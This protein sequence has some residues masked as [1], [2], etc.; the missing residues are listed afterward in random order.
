MAIVITSIPAPCQVALFDAI[1]REEPDFRAVYLARHDGSAGWRDTPFQHEGIFLEEPGDA[2]RVLLRS[3]DSADLVVFADYG[4]G[5]VRDAMRRREAV[6]RPWCFWGERPGGG[7][8]GRMWRN[9]YLAPLHRNRHAA[10]WGIGRGAVEEYRREFGD[11]RL[12]CNFPYVSDLARF[13]ESGARRAE[14]GALRILYAGALTKRNGADLVAAAFRRLAETHADARLSVIGSGPLRPAMARWLGPAAARTDFHD[15][16]GWDDLPKLCAEADVLCAPSRNDGWGL[17][18]PEAMA[19]GLPVVASV[20]MGA[21]LDLVEPGKDGWL[22]PG[23]SAPQLYE[24]LRAA[25]D[26]SPAQRT[27]MGEAARSR[28]A[29]QDI[30][31]GV[32]RFQEAKQATLRAWRDSRDPAARGAAA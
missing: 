20:G 15:A 17:V 11:H 5:S 13:R 30:P 12:Y 18:V 28:A 8:A 4:S 25:A 6:G 16:A 31:A 1:A 9:I 26:L 2:Y 24:A 32:R 21:A 19:A 23:D 10:I 29:Q 7:W 27:A 22:V 14:A 3:M